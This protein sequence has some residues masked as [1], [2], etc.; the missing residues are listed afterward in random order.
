MSEC[1]CDWKGCCEEGQVGLVMR[2]T[3]R[4]FWLCHLHLQALMQAALASGR[5]LQEQARVAGIL[6]RRRL[7]PIESDA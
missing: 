5:S 4:V 1:L 3:A 7:E 6:R 2:R